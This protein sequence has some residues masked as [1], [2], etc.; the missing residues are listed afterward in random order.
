MAA[1]FRLPWVKGADNTAEHAA[2]LRGVRGS[3]SEASG[4]AGSAQA[5]S[6]RGPLT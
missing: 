1:V 6:P 3:D 4:A 2:H 5:P